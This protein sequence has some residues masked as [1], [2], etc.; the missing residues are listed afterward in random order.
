[1]KKIMW[2]L[3]VLALCSAA[4]AGPINPKDVA[5]AA[6]WVAHLD[7]QGVVNSQLGQFV[8]GQLRVQEQLDSKLAMFSVVFGFDPLKDLGSVT[9]Y[10]TEYS[11]AAALVIVKG[12]WDQE[13]LVGLL[14]Q[15]PN[16]SETA[17][18]QHQILRWTDQP[19]DAQD[20]GSRYGAFQASGVAVISR[21]AAAVKHALDV[22]DGKLSG[23]AEVVPATPAGTFL[24]VAARDFT[25]P[26]D[27]DP[28]ARVLKR[29]SGGTLMAGESSNTVFANAKLNTRTALDAQRVR[30]MLDGGL[31]FLSLAI[32]EMTASEGQA[33]FWAPLV[34]GV[35]TAGSGNSVELKVAIDTQTLIQIAEAARKADEAKKAMQPR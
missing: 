19:E 5:P 10:G 15:N 17:H 35:E 8:L 2:T 3:A 33:P 32:E 34:S 6:K 28:K 23:T 7:V 16:F 21:S 24:M 26:A 27:A 1:M 11:P 31:A 14:K 12:K 4:F 25:L 18:G 29:I 13:K 20:D 30:R 9:I 22:L